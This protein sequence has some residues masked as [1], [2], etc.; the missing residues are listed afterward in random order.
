MLSSI[1]P[2]ADEI[3]AATLT[4]RA[5]LPPTRPPGKKPPLVILVHGRAGDAT[6]MWIFSRSVVKLAPVVVAP[7]AFL[8]DEKGGF[9]WWPVR[10]RIDTP[11]S[12]RRAELFDE[13]MTAVE[14][15]KQ[16]VLFAE[17]HYDTD[18]GERYII[19]FSQG[20][21]IAATLSIRDPDLFRGVGLLAGFV[22]HAVQAR[23]SEIEGRGRTIPAY[24][25]AHG[26]EDPVIPFA[27]AEEAREWL[28]ARGAKV[29]FHSEG[30]THKVGTAGVR[31][32][33]EW[34]ERIRTAPEG[35]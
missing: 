34:I 31:A 28:T 13:I 21:A 33:T 30:V 32:L 24:F 2:S 26:T 3:A 8:P 15:L 25:I 7:Q 18:P 10:D 20:A 11:E 9:S 22:P 29:A 17:R 14:R 1:E 5:H 23:V 6:L 35:G 19:G 16:F 27:R 4:Y 12:A